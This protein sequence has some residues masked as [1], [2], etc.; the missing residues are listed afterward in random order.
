MEQVPE[1]CR[2]ARA[3]GIADADT[4][5][6]IGHALVIVEQDD[7][8]DLYIGP[9]RA[10]NL[11]EVVTVRRVRRRAL[12]IHSMPM[13]TQYEPLLWGLEEDDG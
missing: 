10:G 5:H 1:I 6:A 2:T 9:D 4:L 7:E 8:R 3:H 11:L 13:T 12:V